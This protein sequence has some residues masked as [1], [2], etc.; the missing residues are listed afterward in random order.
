MVNGD[1]VSVLGEGLQNAGNI[2][3]LDLGDGQMG[4]A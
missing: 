2:R 1:M 4:I 3:I